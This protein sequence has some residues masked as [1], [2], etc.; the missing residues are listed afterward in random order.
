M[1]QIEQ[2]LQDRNLEAAWQL[3]GGWAPEHQDHLAD[4]IV[5][6]FIRQPERGAE[7]TAA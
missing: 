3:A 2:Q 4:L 7:R 5:E 6:R 1:H